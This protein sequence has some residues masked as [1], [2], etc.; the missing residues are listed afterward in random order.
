M[1]LSSSPQSTSDCSLQILPLALEHMKGAQKRDTDQ[2]CQITCHSKTIFCSNYPEPEFIWRHQHGARF[3]MTKFIV[4]SKF[5]PQ[6]MI[7]ENGEA[8]KDKEKSK[9]AFAHP[10][11]QGYVFASEN[12]EDLQNTN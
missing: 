4:K 12:L 2:P 5:D 8:I 10:I 1:D 7:N 6:N 11:G 9:D 3:V